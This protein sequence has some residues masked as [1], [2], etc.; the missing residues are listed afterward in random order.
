MIPIQFDYVAPSELGQAVALLQGNPNAVPLAGGVSLI[1]AMT[2]RR[3][4]PALLVDL[5]KI[6]ELRGITVSGD[7]VRIGATAT[8][9]EIAAS[10]E[11]RQKYAALAQAV[12]GTADPQARN[13]GTIGGALAYADPA[14]GLAGA[15]LA[16]DAAVQ[17]AGPQGNRSIPIGDFFAGSTRTGLKAGEIITSVVFPSNGL[18]S[19]YV[20]FGNPGSS[21]TLCGVA[22]AVGRGSDGRVSTCRIAVTGAADSPVRLDG[23]EA[24]LLGRAFTVET[25]AGA[26]KLTSSLGL[27]FRSDLAA[28][29]EYRAHLAGVL[30]KRAL[31]GLLL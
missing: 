21:Y 23:V 1:P 30:V 27:N 24:A 18:A 28:T 9:A 20:K 15:A 8:Y 29:A 2:T 7:G 4:A 5:G 16:L 25:I 3:S 17:V 31:S 22:A 10:E 13:R 14:D 6:A 11:I 26:T 12:E 19:N